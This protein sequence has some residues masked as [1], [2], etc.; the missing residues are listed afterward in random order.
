MDLYIARQP[1]FDENLRVFG[2]EL[3]YRKNQENRFLDTD[4]DEA[5][6]NVIINGFTVIGIDRLTGGEPAFVNFTDNLVLQGVATLFPSQTLVIE[7]LETMT[8]YEPVLEACRALRK[9]GYRLALDDFI[10]SARYKAFLGIADIIKVDFARTGFRECR[11]LVERLSNGHVRFLAEKVETEE[12]YQRARSWGYTLFQGYFFSKPIMQ[13]L[14]DVPPLKINQL[15]L[16][17][18]LHQPDAEFSELAKIVQTDVSLSY[19]LLRLV[20]SP[21][22]GLE[23]RVESVHHALVML[24]LNEIRKWVSL[25]VMRA[26]AESKPDEL[27]RQSLIR[28]H[29][30]EKLGKTLKLKNLGDDLFLIGLFSN[31]DVL[32][33]RP[34]SELLGGVAVSSVVRQALVQHE[35]V[36]GFLYQLVRDYEACQWDAVTHNADMLGIVHDELFPTYMEAVKW[37]TDMLGEEGLGANEL[38]D[39]DLS[40]KTAS[41]KA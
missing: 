26:I 38:G 37:C 33:G 20:N 19:K 14:G 21:A 24:G 22:Y 2:Y 7:L 29:M 13:P 5:S 12:E 30:L 41:A 10:D 1:I 31:L 32:M 9:Q 35:G 23:E 25:I 4:A 40:G 15:R 36:P 17:E 11:E 34:M 8:L 27:V 3:L 16:L 39:D 6:S 28:A 18:R